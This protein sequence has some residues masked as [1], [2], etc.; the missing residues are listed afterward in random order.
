MGVVAP[1]EKKMHNDKLHASVTFLATTLFCFP[2]CFCFPKPMHMEHN[3][4][5]LTADASMSTHFQKARTVIH[6]SK[7]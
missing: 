5:T 3:F 6:S 4:M 2:A 1:G 7:H